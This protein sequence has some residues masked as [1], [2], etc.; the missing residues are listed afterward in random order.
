MVVAGCASLT[1]QTD[2][3]VFKRSTQTWGQEVEVTNRCIQPSVLGLFLCEMLHCD[4]A[5]PQ[6]P[7]FL[8]PPPRVLIAKYLSRMRTFLSICLFSAPRRGQKVTPLR[9]SGCRAHACLYGEWFTDAYQEWIDQRKSHDRRS[10][11]HQIKDGNPWAEH[12]LK[13]RHFSFFLPSFLATNTSNTLVCKNEIRW[14]LFGEPIVEDQLW[15]DEAEV[16]LCA[17]ISHSP[18][19]H[20]TLCL[21]K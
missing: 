3:L 20:W 2:F 12:R 7:S 6:H 8:F 15:N 17:F 10:I 1:S 11:K 4:L 14:A 5:T 21:R 19:R 9:E 18:N 13:I 16:Q